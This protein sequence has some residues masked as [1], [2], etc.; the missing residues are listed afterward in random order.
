MT[1]VHKKGSNSNR[2]LSQ[3][4][5]DSRF[6]PKYFEDLDRIK[7]KISFERSKNLYYN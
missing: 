1:L 7:K 6:N 3:A 2:R 5:N 4:I